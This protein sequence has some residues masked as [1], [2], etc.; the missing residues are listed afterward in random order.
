MKLLGLIILCLSLFYGLSHG[1]EN[2]VYAQWGVG[3]A[4]PSKSGANPSRIKNI[5][6]GLERAYSK[7]NA[8]VGMGGWTDKTNYEG[9]KNALYVQ[10]LGGLE[11]RRTEGLFVAYFIGPAYITSP[12][13]LLGSHLQISQQFHIGLKDSRG[14]GISIFIS[15]LSNAGLKSPNQGRNFAG[16]G[17]RF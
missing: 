7:F 8:R 17:A 1:A 13:S 2:R 16:V 3:V 11:T 4:H 14:V 9:A 15:H 6:L 10:Y 5:E 12:D